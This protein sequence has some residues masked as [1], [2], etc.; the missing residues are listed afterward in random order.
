M[1]TNTTL[2]TKFLDAIK[3]ASDLEELDLVRIQFM[4]KDGVLTSA[5]KNMAALSPEEKRTQGQALNAL[6]NEF[7]EELTLKINHLEEVALNQAL[8][9]ETID[10][11]LPTQNLSQGKLHPVTQV[12]EDATR[13]FASMGFETREGPE[14]ET[15]FYNFEALNFQENHPAR[16][17]HDTFY[18]KQLADNIPYLLRTHTST[19]QIHTML[20]ASLPIKIIA[21]GKTYRCDS[22]QTHTPMFHQIEGLYIDEINNVNMGHMKGCLEEFL[23]VF[24]N[25]E[26]LNIRLRPSFFPFTEPSAEIDIGCK[27][28]STGVEIGAGNDWLEILGC[29]MV[30][31]N[32]L[33]NCNIDPD[34]YQGFAFGMGVERLAMLKYNI[35]D[36]R[37]FFEGDVKWL[38]HYGHQP[39]IK[40]HRSDE[41]SR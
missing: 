33:R 27:K 35:P 26:T 29:G 18:V 2:Q 28:S 24:F 32:V 13:I 25:C 38:Q 23:R 40:E 15:D 1:D 11:T 19:V 4:G 10:V 17:M 16:Q 21:P 20:E 39:F 31:P 41:G 9:K 37:T 34:Q 8:L 36:L 6:K 3:N 12:I 30:H 14:I 7:T 5:L 22:D